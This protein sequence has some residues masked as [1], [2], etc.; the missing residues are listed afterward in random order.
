MNQLRHY[1]FPGSAF[2]QHQHRNVDI[3]YQC[4]LRP[5]L[6]HARA[7]GDKKSLI[8]EFLD[9]AGI[10]LLIRSQALINDCIKLSFLEWLRNVIRCAQADRLHHLL[11]VIHAG[12]HHDFCARL[13]LPQTLQRFQPINAGHE[14]IKQYQVGT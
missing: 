14:Q 5:K 7:S 9:I 8:A 6:A 12:K 4:R 11:G 2:T 3:R 1:F 13:K 10:I